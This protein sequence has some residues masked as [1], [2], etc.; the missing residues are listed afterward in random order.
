MVLGASK[1]IEYIEKGVVARF[2]KEGNQ[3]SPE[4]FN[5][6][7]NSK[8]NK[9][10]EKWMWPLI[11]NLGEDFII[12]GATVDL[13]LKEVFEHRGGASLFLNE[14]N[15]GN[16]YEVSPSPNN[17]FIIEPQQ[18]YLVS[19][20]EEVNMPNYLVAYISRRTTMFRSGISLEATYTNPG[21]YG[22]LTLMLVNLTKEP[23]IIEKGFRIAQIAFVKI[24]GDSTPYSGNWQGG[25]VHTIGKF[26]PA[27]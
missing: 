3:I 22:K 4:Q 16:V 13:R 1:I 7:S 11:Q 15:T 21:Y 23:I 12:E 9:I 18:P 27:R 25:K 24:I 5:D 17:L 8:W 10:T 19:T 20:F 2:D 14:R 26:D 6:S